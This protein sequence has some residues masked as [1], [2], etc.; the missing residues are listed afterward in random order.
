[1]TNRDFQ[2]PGYK[3]PVGIG[4]LG[5]LYPAGSYAYNSLGTDSGST[6]PFQGG[7]LGLGFYVYISD[8]SI[9][10]ISS[11]TLAAPAD[12]FAIGES[13]LVNWYSK[14]W[15]GYDQM[16]PGQGAK[17]YQYLRPLR[18]G[19]NYN[20]LFCDNHVEGINMVTLFSVTNSAVRWN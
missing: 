9:S 20:Q 10:P 8:S 1:W 5:L 2:C 13:S 17:G 18:H 16:I 14:D 11:S 7:G 4:S 12:M 19:K 3:G 15:F 6:H